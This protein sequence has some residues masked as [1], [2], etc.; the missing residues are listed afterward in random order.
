MQVLGDYLVD[1]VDKVS[2]DTLDFKVK[3]DTKE[4]RAKM[5]FPVESVHQVKLG[6][7]V[8]PEKLDGLVREEIEEQKD[9][10]YRLYNI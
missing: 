5:D 1:W 3:Q 4:N 6:K 8:F 10:R 7:M 2:P 9:N